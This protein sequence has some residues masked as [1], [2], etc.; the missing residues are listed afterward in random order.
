MA[1]PIN[2]ETIWIAPAGQSVTVGNN[3]TV[4]RGAGAGTNES[5]FTCRLHGHP[6]AVITCKGASGVAYVTLDSCGFLTVTTVSAMKDFL[7][8][9]GISA[10]VSRAGGRLSVRYKMPSGAWR[11][12]EGDSSLNFVGHRYA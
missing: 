4:T 11:E 8:L 5:R 12:K 2:R 7:A 10:G 1:K 3:R 6:V 9:F